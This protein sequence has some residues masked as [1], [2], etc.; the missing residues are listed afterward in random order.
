MWVYE[1]EY[2]PRG[3]PGV[4][5]LLLF[6]LHRNYLSLVTEV[7]VSLFTFLVLVKNCRVECKVFLYQFKVKLW[8]VAGVEEAQTHLPN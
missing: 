8:E 5:V 7:Q 2:S 6:S 1:V 4:H 3:A